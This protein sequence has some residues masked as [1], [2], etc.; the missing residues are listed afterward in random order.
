MDDYFFSS[1]PGFPWS[2]YPIGLPALAIVA[3]LLVLFTIWTYLGHPQAT[4]RRVLIVLVLRLA[5]LVV[6]LVTA[7]RPTVGVNENPKQPSVLI[8][9]VDVSES[10]TVKDEI[11]GQA[12][13]DAIRKTLEKCQPLID[14]LAAEQGVSTVIYK[15]GAPDFNEATSRWEPNAPADAKRSDYGVALKLGYERWQSE[16][17][18]RAVLVIGDGAENGETV[19]SLGEAARWSRRGVK[20]FTFLTGTDSNP[21]TKDIAVTA[22]E[23]DPSPAYIKNKVTVTARVNAP[24]FSGARVTARVSIN[25]KTVAQE[26]FTLDREKNNEL[27]IPVKTP[28]TPGEYKVKVEVGIEKNDKIEA[29]PGELSPLNNWSETYLTVLKEGVRILIVDQ[30]RWEETLLRDA[31]RREPKF[32]VSE[33]IRQTDLTATAAERDLLKLEDQAYDVVIIGNVSA[34]HLNKAAPGFLPK[35]EELVAK[36]GIGVMFL[37]G[38]YAFRGIPDALL[39]IKGGPIIDNLDENSG[40]PN[41]VYPAVPT[42]RGIEKMFRVSGKPG[43]LPKPGESEKLWNDLNNPRTGYL[44]NGYNQLTVPPGGFYTVYAWTTREPRLTESGRDAEGDPLLVGSERGGDRGKGRWLA[45]G[46][47]DTYLWRSMGQPKSD[48]GIKMHERFWKQCVLWLAHR[49]EAEGAI[50]VIPK[51][52]QMKVT[53]EQE[54]RIKAKL[55]NGEEDT[56]APLTVYISPLPPGAPEPKP[57]DDKKGQPQL[58]LSDAETPKSGRKVLFRAPAPGEYFVAVTTPMKDAAGQ[59]MMEPDPTKPGQQRPKLH[60]GTAKFIAVPDVSDEMLFVNAN[61]DFMMKLAA[62]T[63]G[64]ALKLDDLPGFLAELKAE[65]P[66][67]SGKKPKYYPDWHRNRSRGFLPLWLV[68]FTL[69]LGTEWGLRRLWGM[70]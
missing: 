20:I 39:P 5:A 38:E 65:A 30:L 9:Y 64:K 43:E 7:V 2:I 12:R 26:D 27:K 52:R 16:P 22:I 10:M 55:P 19:S 35:L 32:D 54:I 49:D 13:I 44:L 33:V 4:R 6:A 18:V 14:E 23:C 63:G 67:D 47:F 53:Q 62:P 59:V 29:L 41:T 15:L 28:E 37:G 51:F 24:N 48:V 1:R 17:R 8:V 68:I 34:D 56:A 57:E 50:E 46:A 42:R 60:R 3:G 40:N 58:V 45:F 25:D 21:D 31:L 36:K 66:M 69:L 70:V 11:G 61:Q